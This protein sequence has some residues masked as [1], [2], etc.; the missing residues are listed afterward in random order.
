VTAPRRIV[1][2]PPASPPKRPPGRP[3]GSK[4]KPKAVIGIVTVQA[5]ANQLLAVAQR[6]RKALHAALLNAEEASDETGAPWIP[7]ADF[8]QALRFC[9][10]TVK[11]MGTLALQLQGKQLRDA[12]NLSDDELQAAIQQAARETIAALPLEELLVLVEERR[13]GEGLPD[14]E[15]GNGHDAEGVQ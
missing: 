3:P 15:R 9:R 1:T 7:S 11:D 13:A 4:N 6:T 10:E 14:D 8:L 12:A 2:P 5:E